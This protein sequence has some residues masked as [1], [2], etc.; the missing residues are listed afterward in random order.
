MC[1][2]RPRERTRH[3]C[4]S[5]CPPQCEGPRLDG[6]QQRTPRIP[7]LHL[8]WRHFCWLLLS[9]LARLPEASCMC[10]IPS[11]EKTQGSAINTASAGLAWAAPVAWSTA[12]AGL[13]RDAASASPAAVIP[14]GVP[15]AGPGICIPAPACCWAVAPPG[16]APLPESSDAWP[17]ASGPERPHGCCAVTVPTAA[18]AACKGAASAADA[19]QGTVSR[20]ARSGENALRRCAGSG[21]RG[22][23][24]L[25]QPASAGCRQLPC[26]SS[27]VHAVARGVVGKAST[28]AYASASP[29]PPKR[30]PHQNQPHLLGS[31]AA[32]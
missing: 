25:K 14:N 22:L 15:C 12:G 30:P 28:S 24:V 18:A 4:R 20:D 17:P 6:I 21:G 2:P 32:H 9:S 27:A 16:A 26:G 8:C 23:G 10:Q 11:F 7:R 5:C 3:G 13:R 1:A 29:A 31:R 19:A